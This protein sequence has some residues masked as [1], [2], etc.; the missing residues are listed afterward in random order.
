[1]AANLDLPAMQ[2]YNIMCMYHVIIG[3]SY[4]GIV[5][6]YCMLY[7]VTIQ[8]TPIIKALC[9]GVIIIV[10]YKINVQSKVFKH[11]FYIILLNFINYIIS[12]KYIVI[13]N[14]KFH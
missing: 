13:M 1:M 6:V 14:I 7:Y 3:N 10:K 11:K 9:F 2:A 5:T 8:C 4:R 12:V